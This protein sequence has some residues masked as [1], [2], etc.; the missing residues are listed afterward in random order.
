MAALGLLYFGLNYLKGSDIFSNARVFYA[1]Y[2]KVDGLTRDNVV[3]I[4]G[5]KVGRVNSITLIPQKSNQILV[6]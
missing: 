4:N 1:V 2:D 5:F 6:S 3:L